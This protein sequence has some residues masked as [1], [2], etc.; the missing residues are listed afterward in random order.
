MV[1]RIVVPGVHSDDGLQTGR[2][3]RGLCYWSA[4]RAV[5]LR[6]QSSVWKN[7]KIDRCEISFAYLLRR[8]TSFSL[9]LSHHANSRGKRTTEPFVET[10]PRDESRSFSPSLFPR[11]TRKWRENKMK[12]TE[13]R[14]FSPV[15][16]YLPAGIYLPFS[17]KRLEGSSRQK[18][19]IK[20]I[21]EFVKHT[22]MCVRSQR[23][24]SLSAFSFNLSLSELIFANRA[25][26]RILSHQHVMILYSRIV[27]RISISRF[28]K[29]N[30]LIIIIPY[31]AYF[32][33]HRQLCKGLQ[34]ATPRRMSKT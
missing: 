5:G 14:K 34:T 21:P 23:K 29:C 8:S 2:R 22:P 16:F 17:R 12:W 7:V 10:K 28:Q 30:S 19:N 11:N 13:K 4:G 27:R 6:H 33:A 1:Q 3:A 18:R 9:F 32:D 20:E 25:A 26:S 24:V 15:A 31:P